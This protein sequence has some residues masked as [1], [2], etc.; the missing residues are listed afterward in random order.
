MAA[1]HVQTVWVEVL[2]ATTMSATL[3]T[4]AG[5]AVILSFLGGSSLAGMGTISQ[6]LGDT[7]TAGTPEDN[8]GG[9][10]VRQYYA[11]NVAG[12]STTFRM[13]WTNTQFAGMFV[14]EVYGLMASPMDQAAST[15]FASGSATLSSGTTATLSQADE[16]ALATFDFDGSG[17]TIFVSVSNGFTAPA[18]GRQVGSG[19]F[20]KAVLAYKVLSGTSAVESTCTLDDP[21]SGHAVIGTYKALVASPRYLLVRN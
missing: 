14:T 7:L 12:G 20:P 21:S 17:T 2:S 5:N 15:T 11:T 8:S 6:D 10:Y 4:T 18:T 16:F 9:A 1:D 3:T 19:H 13:N